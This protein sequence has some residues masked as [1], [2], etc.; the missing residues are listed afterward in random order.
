MR[1]QS[2]S[3]SRDQMLARLVEVG[4]SHG[5]SR[6]PDF[7]ESCSTYTAGTER[8]QLVVGSGMLYA[9]RDVEL[10]VRGFSFEGTYDDPAVIPINETFRVSLAKG[11]KEAPT[12]LVREVAA[13]EYMARHTEYTPV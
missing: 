13:T 2:L 9:L 1:E 3:L 5:F 10:A 6:T 4:D 11:C 12:A 7:G 8:H